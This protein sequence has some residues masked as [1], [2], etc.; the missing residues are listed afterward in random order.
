MMQVRVVRLGVDQLPVERLCLRIF[1]LQRINI[2]QIT[3]RRHILRCQFDA[4]LH[5]TRGI[6]VFA[7]RRQHASELNM[8]HGI[9]AVSVGQL[10]QHGLRL[11]KPFFLHVE[12]CQS[13]D[14]VASNTICGW[15]AC[16][17]RGSRGQ[18]QS[19][20]ILRFRVFPVF[21][22]VQDRS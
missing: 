6:V 4:R 8:N 5:F 19:P 3:Y 20:L 16:G 21:Q 22:P 2:R 14:R 7:S 9:L 13:R 12:I 11:G 1:F 10:A 15:I 18:R 17:R